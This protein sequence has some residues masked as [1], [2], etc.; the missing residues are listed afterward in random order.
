MD[1]TNLVYEPSFNFFITLTF[2]NL[3]I[4]TLTE[5]SLS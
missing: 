1:S 3:E 4:K 5:T 2:T